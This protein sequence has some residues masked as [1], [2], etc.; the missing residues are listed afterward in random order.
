MKKYAPFLFAVTL[1]AGC[2]ST[3]TI[4]VHFTDPRPAINVRSVTLMQQAPT[5]SVFIAD[6]TA[7]A[8]AS[9][10]G[11]QAAQADLKKASAGVGA[12]VLVIEQWN[13]FDYI[14]G[15]ADK[16]TI[17]GKAYYAPPANR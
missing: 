3:E 6:L 14:S 7:S 8:T 15:Y 12:N 9:S 17:E 4:A 13:D 16:F 10:E 2:S 5:N 1:V 11:A